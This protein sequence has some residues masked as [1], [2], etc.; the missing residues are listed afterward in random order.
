LG[1]S[2]LE[3]FKVLFHLL[4]LLL[5]GLAFFPAVAM[6]HGS[7][8][9]LGSHEPWVRVFAFSMLLAPAYFVFGLVLMTLACVFRL[10]LGFGLKEGVYPFYSS[11]QPIRWMGYNSFILV[12]NALFLDSFRVSPLQIY[13]YRAMGAKIGEGV[14]INTAGLADLSMISIGNNTTIGGGVTLICHAADRGMLKLAPVKIGSNVTI[15]LGTVIMPGVE[16]GDGAVIGPRS[17][18]AAGTKIPPKG[19]FGGDPLK[20][21][22]AE[23]RAGKINHSDDTDDPISQ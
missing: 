15:G 10:L 11:W 12:V 21:L 22:R 19:R 7:W 6:L 8:R 23:R 14:H 4:P 5:M 3:F 20:D 13:F 17:M 16:I 1:Q 9:G 2:R 18:V